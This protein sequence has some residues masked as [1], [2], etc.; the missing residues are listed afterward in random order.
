M[1]PACSNPQDDVPPALTYNEPPT[2]YYPMRQS[3]GKALL[4]V[5]SAAEA[6]RVYR[7]DLDRFPENG[8]SLYGLHRSLFEQCRSKEADAIE[9]WFIDAWQ[10]ADVEL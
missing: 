10:H 6:E 7:E 8:W 9:Q 1:G 5:G 4:A 3:L 2:W